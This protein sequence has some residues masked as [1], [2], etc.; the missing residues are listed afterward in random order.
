MNA[1]YSHEI[2]VLDSFTYF[3]LLCMGALPTCIPVYRMHAVPRKQEEGIGCPGDRI[4]DGCVKKDTK[5]K[6]HTSSELRIIEGY[7]F[8]GRLTNH[9]PLLER[10]TAGK[11]TGHTLY[12]SINSIR[13]HAQV[14]R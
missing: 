8:R 10:R 13:S 5:K 14:G 7:L 12:I 2:G 1:V 11:E 3:Y 9:N 6:S 4:T